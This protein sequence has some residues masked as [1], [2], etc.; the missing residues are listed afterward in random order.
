M[1][2]AIVNR[3]KRFCLLLLLT[4]GWQLAM[5]SG[6]APA[7]EQVPDYLI[8]QGK[9]YPLMTLPLGPFLREKGSRY[10]FKMINTANYRGY[11]ATWEIANNKLLLKSFSGNVDGKRVGL[12]YLFPNQKGPVVATWFSGELNV[13]RGGR[14]FGPQKPD[15][16]F[17]IDK[18]KV[19]GKKVGESFKPD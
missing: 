6:P 14:R 15:M 4:M 9:E 17:T 3:V 1:K 16:T 13:G 7:T 2:S 5:G 8:Y 11:N 19:V 10:T 18:G 12:D